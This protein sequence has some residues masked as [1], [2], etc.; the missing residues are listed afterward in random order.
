[1][2]I[3][4]TEHF[5]KLFPR[6]GGP[7]ALSFFLEP[8]KYNFHFC[9]INCNKNYMINYVE[10][11]FSEKKA[12]MFANQE[13]FVIHNANETCENKTENQISNNNSNILN[14]C[15]AFL[16]CSYPKNKIL[17]LIIKILINNNLIN[18]DLFFISF[19]KIHIADFLS[20]INNKFGKKETCDNNMLKL[21]KFLRGK[22]IQFPKIA[23]KNP[24]ASKLLL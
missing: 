18:E 20:F 14:E 7:K 16:T 4:L 21:C 1:M 9:Y 22:S 23:L 13:I 2:S 5:R 24:L 17:P 10:K 12:I 19:P 8:L 15:N 3:K 11:I 6:L